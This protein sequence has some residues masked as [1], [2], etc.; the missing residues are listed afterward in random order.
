MKVFFKISLFLLSGLIMLVS[1]SPCQINQASDPVRLTGEYGFDTMRAEVRPWTWWWWHGCSVTKSDI[2]AGLEAMQ[3]IGI[4]GVTIV[5][6]LDVRD[7]QAH[8]LG[9]LSPEWVDAV[10]HAIREARRL[11]MDADIAPV[12][13]W[14]FGGPWV[15]RQE[16]CATV[17]VRHWTN[18]DTAALSQEDLQDLNAL[19]LM[20]PD[21]TTTDLTKKARDQ[22][23]PWNLITTAKESYY[24]VLTRR[25]SSRVRMATPDGSGPVVDHLDSVAVRGYLGHFD[26]A[27]KGLAKADMPRAFMNDSWEINLNWTP[28][29][30]DEFAKRRGYDL[31]RQLPAFMGQGEPDVVSRVACD[32]RQTVSDLMIDKFTVTFRK[33]A[34][35]YG[36][37]ITGETINEPG[38]ELDINALYDIPQADMGGPRDWF[39]R[40]GDYATDHFFR[41]AKI[42]ASAAHILGKPL[43][44]SETL[45]CMGPILNTPLEAIK[46][47]IDYDFV[48]GVNHTMFHGISYSP[49]EARWP[50]W[51]FYAGTHLGSFNPMWRQGKQLC[52]YIT[53]CQSF[54]QAG[55]PD[56]DVLVYYPIFD[57]WSQ[58]FGGFT[59]PPGTVTMDYTGPPVA[60]ELWRAGHDFDY[61]SDRLLEAIHVAGGQLVAPGTTY[62]ALIVSDCVRIPVETMERIVQWVNE[63]A[64]VILHGT[65]PADVPGL[66][67]LRE[68][69]ER[70]RKTMDRI[71]ELK[72]SAGASGVGHCGKG[73]II[74]GD[75][76]LSCMAKAHIP[77]EKLTDTGL[78]YIR[79]HDKD[80]A[81]YFIT[82]P[83]ENRRIDE[84]IP[85]ASSGIS[86]VVFDP[87]TGTSGIAGMK[88]NRDYGCALHLQL[89]PRQSCIV[90]ILDN[91]VTGTAWS[92]FV[93]S[94]EP[95]ILTGKW[96]VTFLEGGEIIPHKETVTDLVS[97]TE[98]KSD[99]SAALRAF[100]G[101]ASYTL[102]FATPAI[103]ADAWSIDLGEVRHTARVHLNGKVLGDL[104]SR[105]MRVTTEVLAKEGYNLLEVEVANA[106][107][108]RAADLDIRGIPWMKTL[109][110]DMQTFTIGDFLFPWVRKGID[111]IPCPSGL[112]GPVLLVPMVREE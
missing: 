38:N 40:N 24:A 44:S 74:F 99:Q 21:G 76:I 78:R 84:W 33:W 16:S 92:R 77:R 82:N 37:R 23:S 58:R 102:R 31:R 34:A 105:P 72:R 54:L 66:G 69:R 3:R 2:T 93:P 111:W 79:R 55:R 75:D 41:R 8:P 48:A 57:I 49:A 89:E 96:D 22:A 9:Y 65:L 13:G 1:S 32:Y 39:I 15:P 83:A 112:L 35:D 94:G 59:A 50:G 26:Q 110:E 10:V 28:G 6:L 5:N 90:R 80:G 91:A 46:E 43:V 30:L 7:E 86:A 67:K 70:F 88:N 14:A 85:L 20:S 60:G 101:V 12:P 106:P 62:R 25:G 42:P 95:V 71:E 97:W 11:G 107:A 18:G 63:G 29:L 87:M 4:G 52:D 17:E 51:L 64:T 104:I 47:K 61:T 45:T 73:M 36:C 100:S 109:G 56:A 53:R 81:T 27:F 19:V 108:N 103:S 68:Q 98:W